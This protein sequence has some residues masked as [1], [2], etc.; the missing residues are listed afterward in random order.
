MGC[1]LGDGEGG[2]IFP[3]YLPILLGT[4]HDG[5][6][7]EEMNIPVSADDHLELL[8]FQPVNIIY[9]HASKI[10]S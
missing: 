10:K 8:Q 1:S 6:C 3:S 4:K 9:M 7:A 2:K 5:L